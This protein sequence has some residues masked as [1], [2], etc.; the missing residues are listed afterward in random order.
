MGMKKRFSEEIL[1]QLN[2]DN[3]DLRILFT[4]FAEKIDE[5]EEG[6]RKIS[7]ATDNL[8]DKVFESVEEIKQ[9]NNKINELEKIIE[10][11]N[12]RIYKLEEY[13]VKQNEEIKKLNTIIK[14]KDKK[15]EDYPFITGCDPP[16]YK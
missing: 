14:L 8:T 1:D 7:D 10:K 12:D 16:P 9:L 2:K 3:Y 15:I 11:L 6:N 4:K 13:V 5:L